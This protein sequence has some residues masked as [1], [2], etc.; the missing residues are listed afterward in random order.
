MRWWVIVYLP[1]VPPKTHFFKHWAKTGFVFEVCC[2]IFR[3]SFGPVS[4]FNNISA[5]SRL[6]WTAL[7]RPAQISQ[8]INLLC[9]KFKCWKDSTICWKGAGRETHVSQVLENLKTKIPDWL[10]CMHIHVQII[11]LLNWQLW[12]FNDNDVLWFSGKSTEWK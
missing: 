5:Q 1:S 11:H 9:S 6:H 3:F 10:K 2:L 8:V 4:N 12:Y 7:R